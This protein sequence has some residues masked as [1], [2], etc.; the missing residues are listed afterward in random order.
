MATTDFQYK[1]GDYVLSNVRISGSSGQQVDV[2]DQVLELI[3][4]EDINSSSLTGSL[5]IEDNSGIYQTLPIIGQEKL[6]F[7]VTTPGYNL[8]IDFNSFLANI[9]DVEKRTASS[10]HSHIY[11]LNW[12]TDEALLNIRTRI[13][14]SF[15]GLFSEHVETILRDKRY[16][17][18]KK[19]LFV[20]ET[21]NE[22]KFVVPNVRP[23]K[24][25]RQMAEESLSKKDDHSN[26]LFY[27]TTQGYHYR[28]FDSLLGRAKANIISPTTKIFRSQPVN[29]NDSMFKRMA[30]IL[31]Y[32]VIE[33]TD[34][35]VNSANGMY[36]STL[37]QH[38]I[39]NKQLNKYVYNYFDNKTRVYGNS[40][41]NRAGSL[42][43]ESNTENQKDSISKNK[44]TIADYSTS[45]LFVHPSGSSK[46]HTGGKV[47]NNA[48]EWLQNS[49]SRHLEQ[50]Y[51][52][53]QFLTHGDTSTNVGD[54]IFLRIPSNR[55]LQISEGSDVFD[56]ILSGRYV[57]TNIKHS[58]AHKNN[59]HGMTIRC[60]K[61]SVSDAFG[62]TEFT[63]DEPQLKGTKSI[64]DSDY[65]AP[66][67]VLS[68]QAKL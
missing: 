10:E 50:K 33:S 4:Y 29:P 38:D 54:V 68:E 48:K 23:F 13:S 61:D 9:Y 16:L 44:K 37:L 65:R 19:P 24:T 39:F 52:Q 14:Q 67:E 47:D 42:V 17:S 56:P 51:F 11:L 1:P 7:K 64:S 21:K 59:V 6:S 62:S 45:T 57:I 32:E 46:L 5:L 27:E 53:V 28:S 55:P 2:T 35:L 49:V 58:I 15:K 41:S 30:Q 40:Q 3:V 26:Y 63:F 34:T 12:T 22:R 20:E 31:E 8:S 43:S 25:I 66:S 60:V 18:S 36:S